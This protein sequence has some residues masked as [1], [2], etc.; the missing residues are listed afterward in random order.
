MEM[1]RNYKLTKELIAYLIAGV[2][3]TIVGLAVYYGLTFTILDA[4]NPLQLQIANIIMWIVAVTFAY[5]TNR[6][7]VFESKSKEIVK[8]GERTI[9]A[10]LT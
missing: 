1:N 5:V 10:C 3:T 4:S 9:E 7:F 6:K 2:L 8:E